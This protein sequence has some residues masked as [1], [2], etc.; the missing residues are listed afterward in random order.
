METLFEFDGWRACA[1]ASD[2][3]VAAVQRFFDANPAYFLTVN[4]EGPAADEARREF[5]DLPPAGMTYRD[6]WVIGIFDE[7]GALVGIAG[8]LADLIAATVWH[9][10][11]FVIASD[12]HGS[13]ASA[14]VHRH[15][16]AWMRSHGA[17]W[18]R[19]GVVKGSAKAE[20]FWEKVGYLDLRE[21]GP[22]AMGQRSNLLR[23]MVK[24][25]VAAPIVDYLAL[26]ERDRPG[27]P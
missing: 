2:D 6:R 13:G 19:L 10:G 9:I 15:L 7:R 11:L 26:V 22:V 4:G 25:L 16:E 21:R 5:D 8:V 24:P 3:E 17:R 14:R 20:R 12:L 1:L 18:I 23:V 27:A